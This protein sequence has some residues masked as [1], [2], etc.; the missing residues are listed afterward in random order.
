MLRI[1]RFLA[2]LGGQKVFAKLD[3]SQVLS[4]ELIEMLSE[5]STNHH[6]S[7]GFLSSVLLVHNLC[8]PWNVSM[9]VEESFFTEVQLRYRI[10]S[11]YVLYF[12]MFIYLFLQT[13]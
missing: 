7:G 6:T 2:I 5:M 9:F 11:F 10:D 1:D 12:Y 8:C 3:L 4:I 13:D